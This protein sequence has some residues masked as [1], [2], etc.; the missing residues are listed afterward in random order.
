MA[1]KPSVLGIRFA[2]WP[3]ALP[4]KQLPASSTG[5]NP[6][7]QPRWLSLHSQ[8]ARWHAGTLPAS[9]GSLNA[10]RVYLNGN[11]IAGKCLASTFPGGSLGAEAPPACILAQT[12]MLQRRLCSEGRLC[13]PQAR[14]LTASSATACSASWWAATRS[15]CAAAPTAAAV[16]A[17]WPDLT[18]L[19]AVH[20]V[21]RLE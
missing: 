4:C 3:R 13:L 8:A 6:R 21:H 20:A 15:R 17:A 9:W 16:A 7:T 10:S 14:C 11:N 18:G 5:H 1:S 2:A 19:A 12:S